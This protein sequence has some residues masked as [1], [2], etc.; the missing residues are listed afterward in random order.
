MKKKI[1]LEL[2]SGGIIIK[3]SDTNERKREKAAEILAERLMEGGF[4]AFSERERVG[5]TIVDAKIY[6]LKLIE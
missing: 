3:D 4:V 5:Y 6:A 1:K 2:C